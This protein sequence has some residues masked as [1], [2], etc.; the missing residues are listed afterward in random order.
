MRLSVLSRHVLICSSDQCH[1]LSNFTDSYRWVYGAV[2][3]VDFAFLCMATDS[4]AR[5][6]PRLALALREG[7]S[8]GHGCCRPR[9]S[10]MLSFVIEH[11]CETCARILGRF[12][13]GIVYNKAKN[14]KVYLN[15]DNQRPGPF[16]GPTH[17]SSVSCSVRLLQ[18][19]ST[20]WTSSVAAP[21][22]MDAMLKSMIFFSCYRD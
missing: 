16:A 1:T 12:S 13:L 15:L 17:N 9:V 21:S 6:R 2:S 19:E 20:S 8:C 3:A 18:H 4:I 11:V 22:G 10:G 14:G 5:R 7:P